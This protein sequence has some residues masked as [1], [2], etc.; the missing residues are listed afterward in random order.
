MRRQTVLP[1]AVL[2]T[3]ALVSSC[4]GDDPVESRLGESQLIVL[5]STQLDSIPEA[6]SKSLTARVMDASG[7]LKS[8]PITWRST[9][10]EV[11]AVSAGLVTGV[12]AGV[13]DVIASAG[14]A[15]DTARIVVTPNEI[16]VD[17]Q[18]SAAAVMMGDTLDFVAK[19]RDRNGDIIPATNYVWVVSDT[20]A[21]ELLS[22]G[23]VKTKKEGDVAVTVTVGERRGTSTIQIVRHPVASVTITPGT[24]N[25]Y[26]DST[27]ELEAIPRDQVGRETEANI[28]WGSSN[29][30]VATVTQDGVVRGVSAGFAVIT[31]TAGSKTASATI[32][33][34]GKPARML[35]L[36]IPDTALVG[37][38][39]QATA[40]PMDAVGAQLTGRTI[41][42]QS[43]NPSVATITNTGIIKGVN[44]GATNISA[45]VDGISAT[46]RLTVRSRTAAQIAISPSTPSARVGQSIQLLA[47]ILDAQ[48]L[49]ISAPVIWS[50]SNNSIATVSSTGVLSAVAA[51]SV[52]INA[53]YSGLAATAVA[54]VGDIAV[55]SLEVSP[56]AASL[57]A[58]G[59]VTLT[60]TA[61]AADG[62]ILVGR[63]V[64]WTSSNPTV[65]TVA[66][67]GN[68]T[69]VG[70]GSV[71][72]QASVEGRTAS[73]N[74]SVASPP[75]APVAT[76]VVTL[77]N[78]ALN[79]GQTTQA[80]AVLKDASGNTLTGRTITWSSLSDA[81]AS[82]SASG[83]VTAKGAG[84]V[85]IMA[86]SEGKSGTA[87]LTVNTPPP[88]SVAQVQ[89][90]VPT[91]DL[92]VGATVQSVV[93]LLDAQ[94]N[95]LT[96]RTV[97]YSTDNP[98]IL[99]VSATGLL[100]GIAAGTT[101]VRVSSGGI[102]ASKS[103]RVL[104]AT[105][106][107]VL[108]SIVVQAPTGA[109]TVGQ[110]V[111]ATAVAKDQNQQSMSASFTWTT[112]AP[113]VATVSSNGLVTGVGAGSV[114]IT[115]AS[116]GI[117][118][119]KSFTITAPSPA[120]VANVTVALIPNS[121]S[122]G[123]T[124]QAIVTLKDASGNVLTGR[125]VTFSSS[126]SSVA[127]VTS[128]GLVT[129]VAAGTAMIMA[130][131]EGISSSASL[132][133]TGTSAPILVAELPRRVPTMP[134]GLASLACT[135]NVAAGGLQAALNAARGGDVLCLTGTHTGSFSVP[136]RTDAGWVVIRSAGTIP[137]GRMRPSA[138]GS[139]AKIVTPMTGG[140]SALRF[141]ARSARTLVLGVELTSVSSLVDGPTAIVE[142]GTGSETSLSDLPTDIVFERVYI[143]GW[144]TQR[145][146]R[147]FAFNGAAQTV[148]DSW[149]SEI[150]ALAFDSQCVASWNGSGP[151]L[152]ENNT[153]EAASENIAFGGTPPKVPGVVPSD[154]TIRRNHIAKP[155][156]W[157][158]AGWNVKNLV[159]S[160]S[161]VRVL[162][163][164]NVLEGAWPE[165]QTGN[166]LLLKAVNPGGCR[167]C[168]TSDWTF[169][170]NLIRSV[171]DGFAFA[172]RSE[173]AYGTVDSTVQ[174]VLV[175][176]NW[177]EP[178]GAAPYSGPGRLLTFQLDNRN[179]VVRR[180]VFESVTGSQASAV[181][182]GDN[183][184]RDLEMTG[185]VFPRG[186]YGLF[187]GGSSEGLPSWT[188]GA[189]GTKMWSNQMIGSSSATYPAGTSW[190]STLSQAVSRAGL[191]R[192]NIDARVVGVVIQP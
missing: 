192:A 109:L 59:Q 118:G 119:T 34:L 152:I 83:L 88:S 47:R 98:T 58:N 80:S 61:R 87:S 123:A 187:A 155:L 134:S 170:W 81:V 71:T 105:S 132:T 28:T 101:N 85:A 18:P 74:I 23:S 31:A 52:I 38:E 180:N 190:N 169:R 41:A 3:A 26:P 66:A 95:V 39:V 126:S 124:S 177:I 153:L 69:A 182:F 149:C 115:A 82:V 140:G 112:S 122:T 13:A 11:A 20:S 93:T 67:T 62:S 188:Y 102:S 164:D 189:Q 110:S 111:Q 142:V 44:G 50:S 63:G 56:S 162:V 191:A 186:Q 148:R 99:G 33:V 14:T 147:A 157:K 8:D 144:P 175:E 43:S 46:K 9:N 143:H 17:V 163:E 68:V 16:Y 49:E 172:G 113:S 65:A 35:T 86:Q 79:V 94:G 25:V 156:A 137:S 129:A 104:S 22:P 106:S 136:P 171:S 114:N 121:V 75:P 154:I 161:S 166:I 37:I 151:I 1:L 176:D 131:S 76:V 7:V 174:R 160:K 165:G 135:V 181:I 116:S 117:T 72:I 183:T 168:T 167:W 173:V 120:A 40:T 91:Q 12:S 184:T 60:A 32:N 19:V 24:A 141:P 178:M 100:T 130:T 54:T 70:S 150:H 128:S 139:I 185:N 84:T 78:G 10:P 146:R 133:V 138:A 42:W 97:T 89:L 73:A 108:A 159:E 53:S 21:A 57:A 64:T 179:I 103:I 96:G 45:I 77:A 5:L 15:A 107:P 48:G 158:G 36:Q 90:D 2:A 6:T 29:Y 127:T 27:L 125:Q 51:G 145:I 4:K 55:A 30:G 92:A